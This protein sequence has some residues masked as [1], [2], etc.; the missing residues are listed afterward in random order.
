[1]NEYIDQT[2]TVDNL[3]ASERGSVFENCTFEDS[4]SGCI[5]CIDF[6]FSSFSGCTFNTIFEK[7]CLNGIDIDSG[8]EMSTVTFNSPP[9]DN[10]R[11]IDEKGVMIGKGDGSKKEFK[12]QRVDVDGIKIYVDFEEV[13]PSEYTVSS[14][15]VKN[16]NISGWNSGARDAWL[17]ECSI[18]LSTDAEDTH[19]PYD[20]IPDIPADGS[21]SCAIT[22]K[23]VDRQGNYHTDA[24]DD[25]QI[26]IRCTRGSLNLLRTNLVNGEAVVDL[27]SVQETCVSNVEVWGSAEGSKLGKESIKI[28]FAPVS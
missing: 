21:S 17:Q 26:D 4:Q 9:G 24:S 3:N 5:K 25:D 6:N 28:Q 16:C 2:L 14:G 18:E 7:C 20:G 11:I 22:I 15:I 1:M 27:T 23:K 10:L 8:I 19:E 12:Y 13:D